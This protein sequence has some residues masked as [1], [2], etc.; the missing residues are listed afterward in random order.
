MYHSS[1]FYHGKS[2][3]PEFYNDIKTKADDECYRIELCDLSIFERY[4]K[5]KIEL[6][7][8]MG[9]LGEINQFIDT[10]RMKGVNE[11]SIARIRKKIAI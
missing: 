9:K 7:E 2:P 6:L 5:E 10:L 3:S 1:L 4:Y 8:K 11:A